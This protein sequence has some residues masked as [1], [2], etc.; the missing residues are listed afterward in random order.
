V[1]P[2]AVLTGGAYSRA[3]LTAAGAVAI[4]TDCAALLAAGFPDDLS[5]ARRA[6]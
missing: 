5:S 4:Y 3:E 1:R 2:V 6:G